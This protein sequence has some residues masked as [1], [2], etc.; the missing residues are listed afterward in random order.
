M[1]RAF[2]PNRGHSGVSL[3]SGG[4]GHHGRMERLARLLI[5]MTAPSLGLAAGASAAEPAQ[6]EARIAFRGS[7]E[8]FRE[9]GSDGIYLKDVH[10]QWY[11]G[12]FFAPCHELRFAHSIG[13]E[14]RG[15]SGLDKFGT[16][17][18]RGHSHVER[19]RL[20][21]LVKSGPPPKKTHAKKN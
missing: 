9:D 5:I 19:C 15:T 17:L 20:A 14:D 21:S 10:R 1:S 11:R 2:P 6:P 4:P 13:I 16:I 18:V 3:R 12:T 7:I 8:D